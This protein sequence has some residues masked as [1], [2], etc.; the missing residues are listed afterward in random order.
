[1]RILAAIIALLAG[2]LSCGYLVSSVV[3]TAPMV[4]ETTTTKVEAPAESPVAEKPKGPLPKAVVDDTGHRFGII[5]PTV[6]CKHD[7]IIRNEGDAPLTLKSNGTSCICA[8]SRL[9]A[10]EIPS[11]GEASVQVSAMVDKKEGNFSYSAFVLT[12]DPKRETITLTISGSLLRRFGLTKD[13]LSVSGMTPGQSRRTDL[14]AFSQV[15]DD[16]AVENVRSNLEGLE[17]EIQPV[18]EAVLAAHRAE[19]A[20]RIALTVPSPKEW[21]GVFLDTLEFTLAAGEENPYTEDVKL[22]LFR[23]SRPRVALVGGRMDGVSIAGLELPVI[24]FKIGILRPWQKAH[25]RVTL[26]VYDDHRNLS[27]E[28]IEKE[29]EFLEVEVTSAPSEPDMPVL[30]FVDVT[31]PSDAP[32]CNYLRGPAKVQ[33]ATDHPHAPVIPVE[34]AFAKIGNE[35]DAR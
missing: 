21:E 12:N 31:I 23:Q 25:E 18:S 6:E 26:A 28:K 5:D 20:Y 22:Q 17:W 30:Y 8:K 15:W 11:G 7:F 1:M 9:S 29:P 35:R 3:S 32:P 33:I 13:S 16:F 27:I 34:L 10:K 14:V 2:L 4:T 19:S 24:G